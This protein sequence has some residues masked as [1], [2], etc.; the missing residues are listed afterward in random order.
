V[1]ATS[2]SAQP[3]SL[4]PFLPLASPRQ[5][6]HVAGEGATFSPGGYE[7]AALA[8]GGA[9]VAVGAV[10]GPPGQRQARSVY[11]LTRPPGH[12]AERGEGR[13]FCVFN[14]VAVAAAAALEAHGLQRVAIVDFDVHHG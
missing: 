7:I 13:G 3:P 6:H 2:D 9:L 8:A 1:L 12:H 14:N 4:P 11:A 5:G 10:L